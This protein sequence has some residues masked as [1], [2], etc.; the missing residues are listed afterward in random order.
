MGLSIDI[1]GRVAMCFRAETFSSLDLVAI[2][3]VCRVRKIFTTRRE[4]DRSEGVDADPDVFR[5]EYNFE[6]RDCC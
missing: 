6:R 5:G 1:G 3:P 2:G 4:L